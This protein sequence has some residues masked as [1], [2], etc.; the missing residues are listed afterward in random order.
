[1][2]IARNRLH[3]VLTVVFLVVGCLTVGFGMATRVDDE[4]PCVLECSTPFR[5]C[6]DG[7][8][9][10]GLSPQEAEDLTHTI[11]YGELPQMDKTACSYYV[12]T[13]YYC[14]NGTRYS[15]AMDVKTQCLEETLEL[16]PIMVCPP[17][18][19]DPATYRPFFVTTFAEQC[20]PSGTCVRLR[21]DGPYS[22]NDLFRCEEASDCSCFAGAS[23]SSRECV[24]VVGI[25]LEPRGC[26]SCD[27]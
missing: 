6:A 22:T 20:D 25:T 27:N 4:A 14:R 16:C 8:R 5:E 2:T 10:C 18:I 19:G 15:R 23:C 7:L 26:P 1:M 3:G 9:C 21:V 13:A 12:V 24:P 17:V 11:F